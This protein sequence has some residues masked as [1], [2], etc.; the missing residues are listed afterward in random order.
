VDWVVAAVII[1]ELGTDMGVFGN[2]R[3]AAVW[4]GAA[5]VNYES[6]GKRLKKA[7]RKGNRFLMTVLVEA[8]QAAAQSKG[9][10]QRDKFQRLKARRGYKRAL[11]AI[12]HKILVSAFHMLATGADYNHLGDTYLDSLDTKRT[13]TMLMRRLEKLCYEVTVKA[14][15]A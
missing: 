12:A 15:A 14:P 3:R 6:V 2:A 9:T 5:P 11:V 4:A 7:A 1:A 13:A 10:Y 8:A